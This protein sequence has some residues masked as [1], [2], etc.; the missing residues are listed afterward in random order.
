MELLIFKA[1][2]RMML[3]PSL[4]VGKVSDHCDGSEKMAMCSYCRDKDTMG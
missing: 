4:I 1:S 2:S 3:W